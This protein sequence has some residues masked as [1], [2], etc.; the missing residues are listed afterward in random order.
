MVSPYNM[1]LSVLHWDQKKYC[2][3]NVR[4]VMKL[5][6]TTGF[7]S[8]FL[9]SQLIMANAQIMSQNSTLFHPSRAIVI[10]LNGSCFGLFGRLSFKLLAMSTTAQASSSFS[11]KILGVFCA[12]KKMVEIRFYACVKNCYC[13]IFSPLLTTWRTAATDK[14]PW[15]FFVRDF[16]NVFCFTCF[17]AWVSEIVWLCVVFF[18]MKCSAALCCAVHY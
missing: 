8:R 7:F 5:S 13:T 3:D 10:N 9:L 6:S 12:R 1:F 4:V 17:L 18:L 16:L 14:Y 11:V 2:V 15:M